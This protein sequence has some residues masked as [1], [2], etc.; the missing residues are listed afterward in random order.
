MFDNNFGKCGPMF[1]L[2]VRFEI[3]VVCKL[4]IFYESIG[5]I[6]LKICPYFAK[7]IN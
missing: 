4:S 5:E 2:Q 1:M 6:I 7:P 3:F